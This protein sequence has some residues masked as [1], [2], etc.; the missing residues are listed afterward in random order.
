MAVA[1]SI[2]GVALIQCSM[3]QHQ[4]QTFHQSNF[5]SR[6]PSPNF[7]VS[8][9]PPPVVQDDAVSVYS[10]PDMCTCIIREGGHL[11]EAVCTGLGDLARL[12]PDLVTLEVQDCQE[13]GGRQV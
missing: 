13:D 1:L 11:V 5:D 9:L 10:C 4:H 8:T 12:G 7:S 3:Q 6:G 2:L